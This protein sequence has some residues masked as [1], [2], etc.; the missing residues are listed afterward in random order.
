MRTL[1]DKIELA[2]RRIEQV[3]SLYKK[4]VVMCSFGK[5]SMVLLHLLK[6]YMLPV[7]FHREPFFPRKYDFANKVIRDWN[8]T[9]YDY[10]PQA[11]SLFEKNGNIEVMNHY[12]VGESQMLLP[13]GI[14]EPKNVFIC[15]LKDLIQKPLGSF[16]YPWDVVFIGHKNSDVDPLQGKIPLHVDHK[17][18]P[19]SCDMAFPIREWTDEDI[20]NY[21]EKFEVPIH[22]ERYEKVDGKWRERADKTLNPDYFPACVRC[23]DRREKATVFCPKLQCEISNLSGQARYTE[24][25][26]FNY[27]G[28]IK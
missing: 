10:P 7:I 28:E 20:W 3:I 19:G 24:M 25:N 21:A 27:Y 13:T 23:L 8:L 5:D 6:G 22:H 17:I 2:R 9:V 12:Q 26:E 1:D 15:G 16:E 4:P 11:T 18:N 14:Q